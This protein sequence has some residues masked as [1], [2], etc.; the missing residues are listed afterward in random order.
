MHHGKFLN[1]NSIISVFGKFPNM[2]SNSK[3]Y[4]IK[5]EQKKPL[6]NSWMPGFFV[7]P[8]V[9]GGHRGGTTRRLAKQRGWRVLSWLKGGGN[10]CFGSK[11]VGWM[12]V[13]NI[14][15][16]HP[17]LGKWSNLANIFSIG[18]K[19]PTSGDF[20]KPPRTWDCQHQSG[21]CLGYPGD[22]R[23]LSWKWGSKCFSP[24][25]LKVGTRHTSN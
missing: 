12:V 17:Y 1:N 25:P 21:W 11:K 6:A 5:D 18:L 9:P 10:F 13:S 4:Y 16:F 2:A 22:P 15:Y 7:V 23:I 24:K 20:W 14:C 8:R 19:P 3:F